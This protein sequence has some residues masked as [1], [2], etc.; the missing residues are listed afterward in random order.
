MRFIFN[1]T[2]GRAGRNARLLPLLREFIASRGLDADLVSTEGPG[3]ATVL[4]RE[5][6]WAGCQRIVA[7]GGDGTMNETAQALRHAPASLALVPTGSGNGLARHLGLPGQARAALE[8]AASPKAGFSVIDTG[9]VNGMPFFN[10]MGLGLDADVS[11]RFNRVKRRGLPSYLRTALVAFF[12]RRNESL[13]VTGPDGPETLEAVLVAVAN[14]DQYGN[15][16]RIAPGARADDGLLDLVAVGPISPIAGAGLAARLFLGNFDR[17]RHVRRMR[18]ARFRIERAAEG[19]IHTD[20]EVHP[21]PAVLE[22]VVH[23]R[24]LRVITP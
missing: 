2:S 22:I 21:A 10:A 12:H 6:V 15:G 4:A 3:H 5:A 24:S 14:S 11:Q 8:L 7:V 23:P 13:V 20:G 1:P 16:A 19:P 9:S 18:A 17:S